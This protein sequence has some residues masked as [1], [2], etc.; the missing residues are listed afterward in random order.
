MMGL[1]LT[2][3]SKQTLLLKTK[4]ILELKSIESVTKAHKKQVL[5]YL[6]LTG[7]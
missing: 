6:R 2:K 4:V 1:N 7:C 3:D 5:T